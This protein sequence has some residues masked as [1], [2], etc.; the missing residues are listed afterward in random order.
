MLNLIVYFELGQTKNSVNK[1][2]LHNSVLKWTQFNA[3][4]IG[5]K[6]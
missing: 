4:L 2:K 6:L 5:S 3:F 1:I